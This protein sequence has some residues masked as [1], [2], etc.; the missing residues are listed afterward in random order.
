MRE[1][2]CIR[3]TCNVGKFPS[4]VKRQVKYHFPC[5]RDV[6]AQSKDKLQKAFYA[7]GPNALQTKLAGPEWRSRTFCMKPGWNWF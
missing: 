1:Q 4:A 5:D 3:N 7:M 2:G 6:V